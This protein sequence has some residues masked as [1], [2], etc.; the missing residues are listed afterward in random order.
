MAKKVPK[1]YRE[2]VDA[3]KEQHWRLEETE[4]GFRLLA[5]DGVHAVTIHTTEGDQR[6]V[7]N[8]ISRMRRYG[9]RWRGR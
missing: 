2:V 4:N 1:E 5:P 3:A 9:F 7:R 6:G 8:T